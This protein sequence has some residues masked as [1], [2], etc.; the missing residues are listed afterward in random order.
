MTVRT[1]DLAKASNES[2][3]F[4][5]DQRSSQ[6]EGQQGLY[7]RV[8]QGWLHVNSKEKVAENNWR[9]KQKKVLTGHK[10]RA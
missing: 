7:Y 6:R 4:R 5:K 10:W 3:G 2:S 9:R 1:V 8:Q